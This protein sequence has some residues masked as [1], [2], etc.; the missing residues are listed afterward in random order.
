MFRLPQ[1][2]TSP[3]HSE[4]SSEREVVDVS[5]SQ[6]GLD[7]LSEIDHSDPSVSQSVQ[8]H[9]PVDA[10]LHAS[11]FFAS[12][13]E[14]HYRVRAAELLNAA[15]PGGKYTRES[16]EAQ[17]L[18]N[19]MYAEG[20]KLLASHGMIG[21]DVDG[22]DLE[23]KRHEYLTFLDNVTAQALKDSGALSGSFSKL[24][25]KSKDDAEKSSSGL[26]RVPQRQGLAWP[27]ITKMELPFPRIPGQVSNWRP[28]L[29]LNRYHSDFQEV[30]VLGQGGFGTVYHAVNFLDKQHYA[31]KKIVLDPRRFKRSQEGGFKEIEHTLNEIQTMARLEH[32]NIVRYY[33]AWVEG[34][35]GLPPAPL[36][37][38]TRTPF[39]SRKLLDERSALTEAD[40]SRTNS[41][42]NTGGV[43]FAEDSAVQEESRP[44]Q[45]STDNKP[46]TSTIT[47][48]DGTDIFTDGY[49][50]VGPRP[51]NISANGHVILHIQMSLPP[52][53][54]ATYL[55]PPVTESLELPPVAHAQQRHCYHLLPSLRLFLAVLSGVQY[56]HAIGIAHRDLKP[57]NIFLSESPTPRIGFFDTTCP[58]CPQRR[59]TRYLNARIG[60]FGLVA[61]LVEEISS[62]NRSMAGTELYRPPKSPKNADTTEN[63]HE[64]LDVYALGVLLFE[65]LWKFDTKMERHVLVNDLKHNAKL[66]ADFSDQLNDAGTGEWG[67]YTE[68]QEEDANTEGNLKQKITSTGKVVEDTDESAGG[69][70]AACIL[71]MTHPNSEQRWDC[72]QVLAWIESAL[73]DMKL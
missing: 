67:R 43:V 56:L 29:S 40:E 54:L 27:Q 72:A 19:K 49:G 25:I 12:L 18:A 45:T 24:A 13:L 28:S 34:P 30:K 42:S 44:C 16:P 38:S 50:A 9:A 60:D 4:S 61:N 31:V 65:L 33:G 2:V 5:L 46:S 17:A 7:P 14:F 41:A 15:N 59:N 63:N 10:S 51:S 6:G 8:H 22:P 23:G 53:N 55:S 70:I 1:D 68:E 20:S 35:I 73:G 69:R 48:S 21:S 26:D 66:P 52:L 62:S 36:S 32:S 71:G 57:A 37:R 64:K 3:S 11:F 39:T 58:S 47:L